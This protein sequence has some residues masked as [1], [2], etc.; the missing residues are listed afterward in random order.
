MKSERE[1]K[2]KPQARR[3]RLDQLVRRKVFCGRN[4]TCAVPFRVLDTLNWWTDNSCGQHYIH[5]V[6]R[7]DG[8]VHRVFC[9]GCDSPRLE[10]K[11]GVLHWLYQPNPKVRGGAQPSYVVINGGQDHA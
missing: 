9:R 4:S 7:G 10:M 11:R 5:C 8:T 2:A 6:A 1:P 3:R